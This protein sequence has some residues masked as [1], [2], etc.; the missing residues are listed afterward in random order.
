MGRNTK[1]IEPFDLSPKQV[2]E[3]AKVARSP[4]FFSLFIYV[5][6]PILGKVPFKLYPYQVSVLREFVRNQFNIVLKG[7]Q[8]GLTELIA[9]YSLW[10]AMYHPNKN[11]QIISLKDKVAKRLMRRIKYMYRNLPDHLQVPI[12]NGRRGEYGCVTEDTK[13][14]GL[15]G[16]FNIGD[17]TPK[18][19]G[20]NDISH[21]NV[22]VLTHDGTFE[23]VLTTINKGILETYEIVNNR[24]NTIRCTPNHR[25]YTVEGWKEVSEI[26]ER[27]L[28]TIFWNTDYLNGVEPPTTE[29]NK[30]E[31]IRETKFK[32][33]YVSN[34]GFVY[35]KKWLKRRSPGKLIKMTLRDQGHL[36]ARFK[37]GGKG[38]F[39]TVH[40]LVWETFMGPI[41][42]GYVI[43]HIDCNMHNNDI[44]NLQCVTY[45]RNTSRAHQYN[46]SMKNTNYRLEA[47]ELQDLGIIKDIDNPT[48]Y[49]SG[50]KILNRLNGEI[51]T[52]E[53]SQY[54][55]GTRASHIYTSKVELVNISQEMIVDMEV[56]NSHSYITK[57]DYINHNTAQE[58]EFSN[59]STIISIPTTED[60]GRSEA[61]TLLILDEAAMLRFADEIWAAALPTLS[62]G[63]SAI[64]NSTPY[65]IG[66][67][68]HKTWV[69]A[70]AGRSNGFMPIRL[71]W[72]MHPDRGLDWYRKM[73]QAL[74]PRRTAQE[75]DGD[76]LSSG[77]NVFDLT[78]IKVIEEMLSEVRVLKTRFNSKLRITALPRKDRRY[79][80]GA[81]I[82]SG[83]ASDYSAFSIMDQYGNEVAY[84]K[85]RLPVDRFADLL[86]EYGK[87]YNMAL[88]APEANDIGM[89][90][91]SKIQESGYTNLYYTEDM[92]REKGKRKKKKLS[93]PGWLTTKKNRPVIID[94]LSEDIR[95][96]EV[97]II[98]PF[99]CEEAYTFIYDSSNRPT[100]LGKGSTSEGEDTYTDDS[101]MAT[102]ITNYV[103]KINK[104][105]I[106]TAPV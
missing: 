31:I 43:D 85:G 51:T 56:E 33:Y 37:I 67:L 12:I 48:G 86:M 14:V 22:R 42:D 35:T 100:A 21:L 92:L 20:I 8:M 74:G 69:N 19:R 61:V 99:F 53:V 90:V 50:P 82:A 77:F 98:N 7:R 57:S 73:A 72:N 16:D 36:R 71:H 6:N 49:G 46:R 76:F 54:R 52:K 58:M 47:I 91:V 23:K 87:M 40:R 55:R 97:D 94:V 65:G 5:V 9:M 80:I 79:T 18:T 89:A 26:L 34:T 96:D 11:V 101:I 88:L 59:G 81:D 41:P 3:L 2:K 39:Y 93:V 60:A 106:I 68:Y 29:S 83:R 70:I 66:N 103:R 17:I 30:E 44:N 64:M 84:F 32:N 10:L 1:K 78:E 104:V 75:I 24:G 13:L 63:G 45:G 15:N 62:T 38:V 28:T 102:A 27:D 25:M 4:F 105:N 95:N